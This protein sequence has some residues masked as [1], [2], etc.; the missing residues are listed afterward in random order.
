MISASV[1]Q[2]LQL[3]RI[4]RRMGEI[5]VLALNIHSQ[6]ARTRESQIWYECVPRF[7]VGARHRHR[8]IWLLSK[9]APPSGKAGGLGVSITSPAPL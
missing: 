9:T 2:A 1:A 4:R 8:E 7:S 6:L 3:H 5:F